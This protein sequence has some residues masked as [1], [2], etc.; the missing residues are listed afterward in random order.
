MFRVR[1]EF[2]EKM[3]EQSVL[4]KEKGISFEV[5]PNKKN[6]EK[7][8]LRILHRGLPIV[9]YDPDTD[10]AYVNDEVIIAPSSGYGKG[11]KAGLLWAVWTQSSALA[12]LLKKLLAEV[13]D[14]DE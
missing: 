6:S 1:E 2:G 9:V 7:K 5:V 4:D 12:K 3:M 11:Q 13:K 8:S 10:R 14:G